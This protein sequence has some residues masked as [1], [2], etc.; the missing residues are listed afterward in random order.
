MPLSII[1]T[2]ISSIYWPGGNSEVRAGQEMDGYRQDT[3]DAR[4][5][6]IHVPTAW[7]NAFPRQRRISLQELK[8]ITAAWLHFCLFHFD[9]RCHCGRQDLRG[10]S[11]PFFFFYPQRLSVI[12]VLDRTASHHVQPQASLNH[13]VV[14]F[15][16]DELF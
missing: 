16:R 9:P 6:V 2:C 11:G 13:C 7:K 8:S 12:T 15:P 10:L 1:S 5:N 14:R 3:A 4:W